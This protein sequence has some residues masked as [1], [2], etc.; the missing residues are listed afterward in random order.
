MPDQL[1]D[2]D[3]NKKDAARIY[4]LTQLQPGQAFGNK[5]GEITRVRLDF[6]GSPPSGQ[7]WNLRDEDCLIFKI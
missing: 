3:L 1:R 4:R 2:E 7:G 6:T 5:T